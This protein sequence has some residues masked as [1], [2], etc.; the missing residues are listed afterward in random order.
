MTAPTLSANT[1][2]PAHGGFNV[3]ILETD[4]DNLSPRAQHGEEAGHI[5]AFRAI[6][7]S[8]D[9]LLPVEHTLISPGTTY[10]VLADRPPLSEISLAVPIAFLVQNVLIDGNVVHQNSMCIKVLIDTFVQ[11]TDYV[12]EL[13]EI[14]RSANLVRIFRRTRSVHGK[15]LASNAQNQT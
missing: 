3:A 12:R 15:H 2:V 6:D 8:D 9:V 5:P 14:V 7:A 4:V 11:T 10:L 1:A 13:I